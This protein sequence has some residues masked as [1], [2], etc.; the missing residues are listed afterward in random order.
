MI[1]KI[2]ENKIAEYGSILNPY[3]QKVLLKVGNYKFGKLEIEIPSQDI[4]IAEF[5]SFVD[6]G[7]GYESFPIWIEIENQ[8]AN[9]NIP[10]ALSFSTY[11]D[12]DDNTIQ[13]KISDMS[14]SATTRDTLK[15]IY[16][17]NGITS[18]IS[19]SDL[20]ILVANSVTTVLSLLEKQELIN[21]ENGEYYV[22]PE[23]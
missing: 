10:A 9:N 18:K 12:E 5:Q 16:Y 3:I 11:Q 13:R 23:I 21:D 15:S 8:Y 2:K 6:I 1:L 22:E 19:K 14:V 20:D 17:L 7:A 4:T